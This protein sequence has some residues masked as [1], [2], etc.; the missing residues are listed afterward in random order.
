MKALSDVAP[1]YVYTV[2]WNTN[3]PAMASAMEDL[4]LVPGASI[5]V[6]SSCEGDVVVR[7]CK[8]SLAICSEIAARIK[9]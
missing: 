2:K 8:H 4:G 5:A 3:A 9:V 7:V 6:V 1:G